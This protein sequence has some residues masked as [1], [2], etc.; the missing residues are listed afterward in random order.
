MMTI[1]YYERWF[2]AKKCPIKALET[3]AAR[4]AYSK[5]T[6]FTVVTFDG[7][8]AIAF[9]EFNNDYVGVGFLDELLRECLSYQFQ[10]IEPNRL[11]L[12]MATHREFNESSDT[13]TVGYTYHFKTSGNVVIDYEDF[14]AGDHSIRERPSEVESNWEAYPT[15]GNY[16]S[17]LSKER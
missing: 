13:V 5:R 10:E 4:D 11:F 12:T 15:F 1:Q 8:R 9:L 16:N 7:P 2:R 3:D 17:L 6:L 14:I